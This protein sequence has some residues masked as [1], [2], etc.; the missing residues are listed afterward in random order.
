MLNVDFNDK[1]FY[2]YDIDDE[3]EFGH[4]SSDFLSLKLDSGTKDPTKLE[5]QAVA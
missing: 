3:K 5:I 2:I 1:N 4:I